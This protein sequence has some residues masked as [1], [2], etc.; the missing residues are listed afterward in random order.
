MLIFFLCYLPKCGS[1]LI[2]SI[3]DW[4]VIHGSQNLG[5]HIHVGYQN[6]TSDH[7]ELIRMIGIHSH[8][9]NCSGFL[10][11]YTSFKC[12]SPTPLLLSELRQPPWGYTTHW[13]EGNLGMVNKLEGL[14][15]LTTEKQVSPSLLVPLEDWLFSGEGSDCA[16]WAFLRRQSSSSQIFSLF[17]LQVTE[18]PAPAEHHNRWSNY[19]F[20]QLSLP[21]AH[22]CTWF[23]PSDILSTHSVKVS[24]I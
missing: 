20:E 6:G 8:F 11:E 5:I 12:T 24:D 16:F 23:L 17:S 13:M 4:Q 21:L 2:V 9:I 22:G 7:S 10:F 3:P 15:P 1:L 14:R 18:P 19:A